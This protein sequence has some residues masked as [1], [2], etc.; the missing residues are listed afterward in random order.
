MHLERLI[1]VLE[2]LAIGGRPVTA[3]EV[4]QATGLPQAHLL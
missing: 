2:A 1:T 3:P 4:Q